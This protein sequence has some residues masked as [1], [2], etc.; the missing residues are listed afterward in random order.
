MF[1]VGVTHFGTHG[2]LSGRLEGLLDLIRQDVRQV[3]RRCIRT[4]TNGTNDLGICNVIRNNLAHFGE[5]PA[6]PFFDAHSI[7]IQFLVEIIQERNSLDHHC[8]HF[9][10]AE[11]ELVAT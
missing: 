11:F 3:A 4:E 8:V 9:I 6:V 10:R 1:H 7:D 5:M 2:D